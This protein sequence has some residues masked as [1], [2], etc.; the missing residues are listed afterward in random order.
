[1]RGGPSIIG[2][3]DSACTIGM[4]HGIMSISHFALR[5]QHAA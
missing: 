1:M 2:D 5:Y 3:I 4:A